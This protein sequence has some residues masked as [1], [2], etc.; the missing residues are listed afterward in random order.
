MAAATPRAVAQSAGE[1]VVSDAQS[2]DAANAASVD[3][4]VP[5][6]DAAI[7]LEFIERLANPQQQFTSDEELQQYLDKVSTAIGAAADK[8]LAAKATDQQAIDAIEWK[9]ESLRIREKLGDDGAGKQTEEFLANLKF[10]SQPAVE[11]AIA[12]DSPEPQNDG[13]ADEIDVQTARVAAPRCR[14]A[15]LRRPTG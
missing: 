8:I 5:D 6:G 10:E 14:P 4:T 13:A 15:A 9:I 12:Q 11:E 2:E 7:L 1:V 3:F